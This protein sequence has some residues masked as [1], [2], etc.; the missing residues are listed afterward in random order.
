MIIVLYSLQVFLLPGPGSQ[1]SRVLPH[2]SPLQDKAHIR[3][4]TG[5][6]DQMKLKP[7]QMLMK[8]KLCFLTAHYVDTVFC[9]FV[10]QYCFHLTVLCVLTTG[11]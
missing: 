6:W 1:V 8:H 11:T 7:A 9:V 5:S 4:L 10:T 3:Q 2:R